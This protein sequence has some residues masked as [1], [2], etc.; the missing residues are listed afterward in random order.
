MPE[1]DEL[2]SNRLLI[3]LIPAE[4]AEEAEEDAK[5]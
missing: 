2:R 5:Q 3:P 1:R 4:E